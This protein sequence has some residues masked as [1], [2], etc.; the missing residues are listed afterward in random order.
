MDA[1]AILL[2][3]FTAVLGVVG[4]IIF[5]WLSAGRKPH[6]PS[7]GGNNTAGAKDVSFWLLQYKESADRVIEEVVDHIEQ[8]EKRI[9][10]QIEET[11][12]RGRGR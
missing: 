1:K 9:I 12:L 10:K 7:H 2:A 5:D 4:K 8:S 3:I 11:R 6:A